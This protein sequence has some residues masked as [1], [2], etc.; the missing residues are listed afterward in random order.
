MPKAAKRPGLTQAL[1]TYASFKEPVVIKAAHTALILTFCT[2]L[3]ITL[4]ASGAPPFNTAL[5]VSGFVVV[6][7]GARWLSGKARNGKPDSFEFVWADF[8][9][10]TRRDIA[11]FFLFLLV[12]I[13]LFAL[14]FPEPKGG[15]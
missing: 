5:V 2:M 3:S 9:N 4:L 14:G 7:V 13:C 10:L 12:G 8:G 1:G 6:L 15:A 11:R